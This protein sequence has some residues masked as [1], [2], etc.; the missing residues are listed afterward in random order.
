MSADRRSSLVAVAL[1]VGLSL[2]PAA[3]AIHAQTPVASS[4]PVRTLTLEEA[5][6]IAEKT[7]E[8][9]AIAEAGISRA[10]GGKQ[11]ARSERM[12]QLF[13]GASYDRT[14]KSEFEGLF[15]AGPTEPGTEPG[16]T[17]RNPS[18]VMCS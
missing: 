8:R 14:L 18:Y 12:P 10:D 15:D 6:S 4:A 16:G 2:T 5:L 17:C 11:L 13:G 3:P 1:S 7:S 9:V